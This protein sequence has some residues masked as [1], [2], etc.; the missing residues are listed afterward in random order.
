LVIPMNRTTFLIDGFNL[1][2]SLRTASEELSGASTKWLDLSSLLRSYLP[3]V[4]GGAQA[5]CIY[6]FSA[7]A[8]HLEQRQPGVTVRHR[9][10]I[11]C[12]QSTGVV[13]ILGRFKSKQVHCRNCRRQSEHFEEK[14]TDVGISTKLLEVLHLDAADTV[15]L[16]TGDTDLAPAV[17]T[18]RSLF[19]AKRIWFVFPYKRKNKE[20]AQL[21]HGNCYIRK[22]RYVQHQLPA[23]VTLATRKTIARPATW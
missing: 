10:Y 18:A 22:E 19:P 2:H 11:E 23:V 16:V 17:R 21:A 12:L 8:T 3:N 9:A 5:E 20:L 13:P 15:V 6:Y 14:E 1:Y 7:L 4:G